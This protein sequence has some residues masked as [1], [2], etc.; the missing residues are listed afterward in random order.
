M[1]LNL[2]AERNTQEPVAIPIQALRQH[3]HLIGYTGTGKTTALI[4]LLLGLLPLVTQKKCV[5][6]IDRLGG[7]SMDLLRWFASQYC[8]AWVR[9]R[10]IYIEASRED[11]VV[12]MNPLLH[13]TPGEGYYRTARAA[14]I[15]LRG[16]A[17]QDLAQMPRLARW[18]FNSMYA[19]AL[20]GLTIADA[21]HLLFP[22]SNLH[23]RIL[24]C[25]PEQ[26][27]VEWE[28]I[29][30]A[31]G[32][33]AE[34]QL[35]S[36]RNRLKP[37]F[38][39]PGLRA[40]FSSA[41]NCLDV[42]RW[43][44][45]HKIVIINLAPMGKL[46]EQ[47]ADTLG[48][49]IVNEIFS[50]ARSLPPELRKETLVILD[51]F[52]RFVGPDLEFSLAESRQL[53]T[54]LLL[55]HQSFSQLKQGDVDLTSLI[56]QAQTRL[57]LRVGGNDAN[58]LAEELA[59]MTYDPMKVK[60]EIWHRSQRVSGH[61]IMDLQS[62]STS[63]QFA[64][65]WSDTYGVKYSRNENRVQGAVTGESIS[66]GDQTNRGQGGSEGRGTTFGSHQSLVPIY[67]DYMQLA[68][69]TYATF[70]EQKY[71]WA[72][73]LRQLKRG[74]G[75]LQI[76][77]DSRLYEVDIRKATH[78]VLALDWEKVQ[79]RLPN[80]ADAYLRLI[81]RNCQQEWFVSPARIAR[82]TTERLQRVLQ[83]PIVL[84]SPLISEPLGNEP[85]GQSDVDL[86]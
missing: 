6:I 3:M 21:A 66:R 2:G 41:T 25:L 47:S 72:K 30:K 27:R 18:M 67:E 56:F 24:N 26:L 82:E 31:T 78:G 48:G 23:R 60:A 33:Q 54:S 75:V 7:F 74:Q 52:Q 55:S 64:R 19:V 57:A 53:K 38:D 69:R 11:L 10:L 40:M 13:G 28:L 59:G 32:N 20:L 12:P 44:R 43:M 79:K 85:S 77:D 81:E 62:T 71:E 49:L 83:P 4:T 35:E 5:F 46:P 70:D 76:V 61:R 51:E 84:Q 68:S 14:E 17:N 36:T 45:E 8:P 73:K 80:V 50:V 65:Q 37:F 9:E 16:W 29:I 42:G 63:E 1:K 39:C 58:I 15:V 34:I 22:Q 86:L